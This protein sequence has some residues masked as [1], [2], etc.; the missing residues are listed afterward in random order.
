MVNENE[1]I[2]IKLD[3]II[4]NRFQPRE[5]F[6]DQSMQELADSI[7]T[8]GVI[9]PIIVRPVDNKYEIIAGE[10]RYKA[11]VMAG[12]TDIPAL[13]KN[14]DDKDSSIIAFIENSQ[15]KDV[16]A[17][18]EARTCERILSSNDL[19]QEQLAKQLGMSQSTLANK[20]RLLTLPV[21]IQDAL[22]HGEISERHAR[23]L[24]SIKDTKKQLELLE[25]IKNEKLTVRELDG[26]IKSM[27]EEANK[28]GL[29]DLP[30]SEEYKENN[31]VQDTGMDF[32]RYE[33][34]QAA[35]EV[36]PAAPAA[37]NQF[38]DFLN[39]MDEQPVANALENTAP[40]PAVT[41]PVV[42]T[43]LTAPLEPV[44]E[45]PAP[46]QE[47][48]PANN[49]FLSFLNNFDDSKLAGTVPEAPVETPAQEVPLTPIVETP[50]PEV[51]PAAPAAPVPTTT[52]A[53]APN[54]EFLTFL[55]NFDDSKVATPTPEVAP[56][57]PAV[58]EPVVETP[59]PVQEAAPAP[60]I[61]KSFDDF[62]SSFNTAVET[63]T[64]EAPTPVVE[65]PQVVEPVTP[66]VETPAPVAPIPEVTPAAPAEQAS[67][68]EFL[69]FLNNFDDSKVAQAPQEAVPTP[70]VAPTV[71]VPAPVV[72][73]SAPEATNDFVDFMKKY[74]AP[75]EEPVDL[76]PVPGIAPPTTVPETMA[77]SETLDINAKYLNPIEEVTPKVDYVENSPN[78]VDITKPISYDSVD[79]I[80]GKLKGVTDE[81]KKSK[82]K[83]TTEETDFDDVYTIT[84]KI[85]KRNFL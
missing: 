31:P 34:P 81:I 61:D 8:H 37:G 68:N 23:S 54:N 67:N 52:E 21:E 65:T 85:D 49:E 29:Y 78:Y 44:V 1:V 42:E 35:P 45:T 83:I 55:N 72:E 24:L 38:L 69:T 79:S 48:A 50:I 12:K 51:A 7:K 19:T 74:E 40:I 32:S 47:A 14:K 64:P 27:L 10:R 70:E 66:V 73:A 53:Q 46:V 63:P 76:G 16:T 4:P 33:L 11:S 60:S 15:R 59:A 28:D 18:E 3:D 75:V 77:T 58:V 57:A 25:K 17:I 30:G 82:Y 56:A 43:P 80:I 62:L 2:T 22:L 36:A 9:Q 71:E 41:E 84:I 39:T 13:V 6:D 5:I 20:L 26:V